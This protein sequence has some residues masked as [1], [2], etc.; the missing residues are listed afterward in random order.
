MFSYHGKITLHPT[1][2][3]LFPRRLQTALPTAPEAPK[4]VAT[5]PE[6]EERYP[7][8]RFIDVNEGTVE[9]SPDTPVIDGR[10]PVSDL[11]RSVSEHT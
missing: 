10:R 2:V 4:T 11:G 1:C 6:N 9:T 8:P 5:T 3:P 7:G